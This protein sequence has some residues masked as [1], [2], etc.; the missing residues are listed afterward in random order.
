[1]SE[2]IT[3]ASPEGAF[4]ACLE[5]FHRRPIRVLRAMRGARTVIRSL[6]A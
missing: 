1:M 4:G 3:I 2:R 5:H 6:D